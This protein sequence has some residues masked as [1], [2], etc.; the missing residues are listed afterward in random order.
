MRYIIEESFTLRK[1]CKANISLVKSTREI[2]QY[3]RV[4]VP[5]ND[6]GGIPTGDG[7]ETRDIPTWTEVQQVCLQRSDIAFMRMSDL[8]T[9]IKIEVS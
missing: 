2:F 7:W 4:E 5:F 1:G 8:L 3:E 9:W 6:D